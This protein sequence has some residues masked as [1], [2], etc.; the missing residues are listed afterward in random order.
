MGASESKASRR[1][2]VLLRLIQRLV[3]LTALAAIAQPGIPAR[4]W[5]SPSTEAL[6]GDK[7]AASIRIIRAWFVLE[8]DSDA[9]SPLALRVPPMVALAN[10]FFLPLGFRLEVAGVE[11]VARLNPSSAEDALFDLRSRWARR[12]EKRDIVVGILASSRTATDLG[13]GLKGTICDVP[14]AVAVVTWL[15]DSP[16]QAAR[17]GRTLAH[18][19][20]HVLG[21]SHD[22]SSTVPS[23][24][25]M[26]FSLMYPE[27]IALTGGFSALSARE[28]AETLATQS[29][30][31][32]CAPVGEAGDFAGAITAPAEFTVQEGT[33]ARLQIFLPDA[34]GRSPFV[35]ITGLP[36][37]AIFSE[38]TGILEYAPRS[39]TVP[40]NEAQILLPLA[41]HAESFT[42]S[43]DQ[44][45]TLVVVRSSSGSSGGSSGAPVI[46]AAETMTLVP[47]KSGRVRTSY[48]FSVS[49]QHG[50]RVECGAAPAGLRVRRGARTVR[51]SGRAN[52]LPGTLACSVNSLSG[53][54]RVTFLILPRS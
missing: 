43:L 6:T 20:G 34:E 5:A 30:K 22:S 10:T 45:L 50:A 27:G 52:S 8:S 35:T 23:S 39:G 46:A 44:P 4:V 13:Y 40:L 25:G 9:S 26:L 36:N 11:S 38:T 19:V 21:A 17:A 49:A 14:N 2:S 28:I 15:G 33:R 37:G 53:V 12:P 3:I 24:Q 48:R 54:A 29:A 31:D 7:N 51:I 47:G 1:P 18:E 16:S 32:E 41:I 42:G